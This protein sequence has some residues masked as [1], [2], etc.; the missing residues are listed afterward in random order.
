MAGYPTCSCQ[1]TEPLDWAR[2]PQLHSLPS[3]HLVHGKLSHS[4]QARKLVLGRTYQ[5]ST[6][7][8][9][10]SFPS[11][12][13]TSSISRHPTQVGASLPFPNH[14]LYVTLPE[15]VSEDFLQRARE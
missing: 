1:M 11:Q 14:P 10:S 3:F 8:F 7:F 4:H 6:I 13:G 15:Q 2:M 5:P 12:T 9:N